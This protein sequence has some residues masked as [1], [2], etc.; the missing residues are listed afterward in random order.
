MIPSSEVPLA[1][2]RDKTFGSWI[3]KLRR[4]RGMSQR[5]LAQK[6]G[7]DFT[8][9]SKL[10]NDA[11]QSPGDDLIRRLAVELGEDADELL[12]LAGKV[13]VDELRAR[14]KEDPEFARALRRL[15]D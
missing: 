6:V 11:G 2:A 5:R 13:P 12:A 15:P 1:P 3:R 7:I 10:E 14:A 4:E 8:Y 9:L